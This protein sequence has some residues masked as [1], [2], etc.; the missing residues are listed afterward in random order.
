M[1]TR[2]LS[3]V[4]QTLD[5]ASTILATPTHLVHPQKENSVSATMKWTVR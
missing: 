4:T 5:R 1:R 3:P 2:A